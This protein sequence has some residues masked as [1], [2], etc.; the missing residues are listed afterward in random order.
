MQKITDNSVILLKTAAAELKKRIRNK[1]NE[2]LEA[3]EI[4]KAEHAFMA[5]DFPVTPE[6]HTLP[7]THKTYADTPPGRPTEA[8]IRFLT[9]F[10]I[11]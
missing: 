3:D 7:K 10:S 4:T 6:P 11:R 9:H 5:V 2:L 8:A 1:L